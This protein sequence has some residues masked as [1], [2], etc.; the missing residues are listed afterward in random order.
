MPIVG[1]KETIVQLS[2]KKVRRLDLSG[3]P[4]IK[5]VELLK[6]LL[7]SLPGLLELNIRLT[8]NC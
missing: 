6:T 2:L 1:K 8:F 7:A 3:N 4:K 5:N